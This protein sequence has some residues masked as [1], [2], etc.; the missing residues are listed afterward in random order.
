MAPGQK[1]AND[2]AA[3][4]VGIGDEIDRFGQS[5]GVDQQD[6]LVQ[7]GSPI[8]IAEHTTFV[9]A[10]G[11]RDGHDAGWGLGQHGERVP[12]IHRQI[13]AYKR[14]MSLIER[15]IDLSIERSKLQIRI[16]KQAGSK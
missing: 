4:I 6:H 7:Q 8:A 10:A 15:W 9:D 12:E 11:Q 14:L 1:P 3:A 13:A 5:Q 2:P 16:A